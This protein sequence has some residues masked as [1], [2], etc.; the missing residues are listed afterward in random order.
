M[1]VIAGAQWNNNTKKHSAMMGSRREGV[2]EDALV[3]GGDGGSVG[4]DIKDLERSG[5]FETSESS[6]M[7]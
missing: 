3:A 5:I 2:P 6:E 4:W 7:L 1:R